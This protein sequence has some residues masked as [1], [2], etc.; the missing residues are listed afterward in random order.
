LGHRHPTSLFL[1]QFQAVFRRFASPEEAS[2]DH[3]FPFHIQP[4]TSRTRRFYQPEIDH[5]VKTG[6]V[7][8]RGS[9][10]QSKQKDIEFLE[11]LRKQRFKRKSATLA[12]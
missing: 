9:G 1:K 6:V 2:A 11:I 5:F 4:I 12:R 8:T 3:L 7:T 10:Q